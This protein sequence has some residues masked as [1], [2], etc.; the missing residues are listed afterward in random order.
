MEFRADHTVVNPLRLRRSTMNELEYALLLCYT[1]RTR[2]SSHIVEKQVAAYAAG[3]QE[4]VASLDAMKQLTI[5]MKAL[6]LRDRLSEFGR[7]LHEAWEWKKQLQSE[8]TNPQIDRLY[9]LARQEGAVGGK[10][11]GAGGG[12]FL[13]IMAPF[14]QRPHVARALQAEGGEIVPFAFEGRGL[15]TWT[16]AE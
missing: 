15:Q 16:V 4:V 12:G 14:Q 13:L 7:K 3:R 2:L 9:G 10:I 1:G 11:L 8:I 5:E 6:L